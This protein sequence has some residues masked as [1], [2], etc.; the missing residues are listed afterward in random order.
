MTALIQ[1]VRISGFLTDS[2]IIT[3]GNHLDLKVN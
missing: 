2:M 3:K 1:A